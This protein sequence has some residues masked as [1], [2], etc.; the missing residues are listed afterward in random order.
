MVAPELTGMS[1]PDELT[2]EDGPLTRVPPTRLLPP[3][4]RSIPPAAVV[5]PVSD[6]V[7]SLQV[8]NPEIV[9]SPDPVSVA[10]FVSVSAPEIEEA[11]FSDSDPPVM[12]REA[13]SV[14]LLTES[15]APE[16]W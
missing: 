9:R 5:V 4:E 13:L 8:N 11:E 1:P 14:R 16:F 12:L 3:L 10:P 2:V 15:A 7:L 6:S